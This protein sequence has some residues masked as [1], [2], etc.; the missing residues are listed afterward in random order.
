M[1]FEKIIKIAHS[2]GVCKQ[3]DAKSKLKAEV[4]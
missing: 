4:C 1:G 2:C 3:Q